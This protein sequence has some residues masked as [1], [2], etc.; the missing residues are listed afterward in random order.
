[1]GDARHAS[2]A[3]AFVKVDLT[4]PDGR[5]LHVE[6]GREQFD[7]LAVTQGERRLR[8]APPT[9]GLPA[10][11]WLIRRGQTRADLDGSTLSLSPSRP[12]P[13]G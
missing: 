10:R 13:A 4:D 2:P 8:P 9:A 3:G 12:D 1:M 7:T 11:A 6:I 5:L